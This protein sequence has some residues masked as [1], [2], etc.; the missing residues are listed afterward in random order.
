[1]NV[2][3]IALATILVLLIVL[4]VVAPVGPLPGFI[5]GGTQTSIPDRWQDTSAIHEIKLE[6]SGTIPRVVIIWVVQVAGEL[7]V[8]G[9]NDSGWVKMLGMSSPVRLRME[10][11]T[12]SMIATRID[13]DWQAVLEAYRDKYITDY[14]DIIGGFPSIEEARET[15]AVFRLGSN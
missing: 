15:T 4:A 6:V 13:E 8:V 1:M 10:D 2:L 5:I 9:A 11:K 3:K 12:Y 14:P 7:H